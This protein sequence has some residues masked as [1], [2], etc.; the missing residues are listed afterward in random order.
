VRV[1]VKRCI[2]VG[3]TVKRALPLEVGAL[4]TDDVT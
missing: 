3:E 1:N 4:N 2:D